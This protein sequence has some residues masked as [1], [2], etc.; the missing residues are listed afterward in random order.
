LYH[1]I[2]YEV[3]AYQGKSSI[4][5]ND[6]ILWKK[7]LTAYAIAYPSNVL[8]PL[9]SSSSNTRESSVAF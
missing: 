3:K 5:M 1:S 7:K 6:E 8:V 2:N 4:V 9:P